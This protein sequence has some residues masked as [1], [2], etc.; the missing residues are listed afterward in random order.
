MHV[1][2]PFFLINTITT[3]PPHYTNLSNMKP[4]Q[5]LGR[6][7]LKYYDDIGLL[8]HETLML[9]HDDGEEQGQ[10]NREAAEAQ[11]SVLVLP[12]TTK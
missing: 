4:D 10:Q 5:F 9:K 7:S 12:H 3:I 8:N 1:R 2:I 11:K 6:A